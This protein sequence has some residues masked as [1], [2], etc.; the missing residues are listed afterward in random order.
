MKMKSKNNQ[1][2][3]KAQMISVV[4]SFI[5]FNAII[6]EADWLIASSIFLLIVLILVVK[7]FGRRQSE[8]VKLANPNYS[9]RM[10]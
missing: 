4:I 6:K 5:L 9:R 8:K 10:P 3:I 7:I 1:E 2:V